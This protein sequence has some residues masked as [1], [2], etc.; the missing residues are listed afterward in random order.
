[1]RGPRGW[2]LLHLE[3]WLPAKSGAVDF[4]KERKI[5]VGH[6]AAFFLS[7]GVGVFIG[8]CGVDF[9][10]RVSPVSSLVMGTRQAGL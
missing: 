5:I 2:L 4:V 9:R 7:L 1:M 6:K 10:D 3:S 8:L